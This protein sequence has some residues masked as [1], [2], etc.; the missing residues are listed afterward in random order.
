MLLEGKN[1]IPDAA[2]GPLLVVPL[3][4]VILHMGHV[5]RRRRWVCAIKNFDPKYSGTIRNK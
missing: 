1:T 5:P 3:D 2:D 4:N